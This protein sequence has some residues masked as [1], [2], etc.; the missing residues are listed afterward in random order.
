MR[1]MDPHSTS[2]LLVNELSSPCVKLQQLWERL[3]LAFP[4][5]IACLMLPHNL[6]PTP[7]W[8]TPSIATRVAESS[9]SIVEGSAGASPAPV[10][11]AIVHATS[12][13]TVTTS[14]T[15]TSLA[16]VIPEP[17]T[18][19]GSIYLL[20][21]HAIKNIHTYSTYSNKCIM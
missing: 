13:T 2:L 6:Y 8:L 11:E 12:T 18:C 10:V 17:S 3:D 5:S 21:F 19:Q 4:V 14:W 16:S 20:D 9:T 15:S 7:L 1:A